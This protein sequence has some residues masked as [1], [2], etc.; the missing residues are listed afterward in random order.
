MAAERRTLRQVI[1]RRQR[2][3]FVGRQ[4]EL[5]LFEANLGY[6]SD[7]ERRRWIFN[8]HGPAGVGKTLLVRQWSQIAQA[9]GVVHAYVADTV[10]DRPAAMAAIA[11]AFAQQDAPL[12]RFHARYR[13]YEQRRG[14]LQADPAAPKEAASL[15]TT[16][17]MR[18]TLRAAKEVPVVKVGAAVLDD[19]AV[20]EGADRLR[21]YLADRLRS[22]EDV[23][24]LL[25]PTEVLSPLFAQDLADIGQQR[26][27][28]LFLDTYERTG[29]FLDPW[30]LAM[31]DGDRY[32][33]EE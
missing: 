24:L 30:L 8:I 7:D 29:S 3:G 1:Q 26:Q 10:Y 6:D 21:K 5:A 12:K 14:E 22:H 11:A 25:S 17:A 9:A 18:L 13:V 33:D 31:L 2:S 28:A 15:W 16:T 23:R 27:L 19:P 4:A 20:I 32:G